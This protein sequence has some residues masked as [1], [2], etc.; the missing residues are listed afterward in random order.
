MG[1]VVVERSFETPRAYEELDAAEAAVSWCLEQHRVRALRSFLS[2][3]R[4]RM[5]CIYDAPDAEAVRRT[6]DEGGLPYERIWAAQALEPDDRERAEGH[7]TVVVQ[8]AL[9]ERVDVAGAWDLFALAEGCLG[10]NRAKL[11]NSYL[12]RDGLRMVCHFYAPDA[13]GVRRANEESG[14][15]FTHVW[16]ATAYGDV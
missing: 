14:L 1:L 10:R 7:S 4:R 15:P 11:W 16:P 3:D 13:E 12:S 6:Q 8:R 5:V 2:R 9:P